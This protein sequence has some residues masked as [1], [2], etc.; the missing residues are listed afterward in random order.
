VTTPAHTEFRRDV[1][2]LHI[3]PFQQEALRLAQPDF[4][5]A[6]PMPFLIYQR[7]QLWDRKLLFAPVAKASTETIVANYDDLYAGGMTFLH[8]IRKLQ[9]DASVPGIVLGRGR[10][11]DMVVPVN[12]VSSAH[13]T[14]LPPAAAGE[15]WRVKDLGSKNGT[16]VG[17]EQLFANTPRPLR[18]GVY[19]RL[20]GTLIGWYLEPVFLWEALRNPAELRRYTEI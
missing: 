7:S 17:E 13:L 12:S 3:E 5:T 15:P 11:Q 18:S 6:Y 2:P 19:L 4:A 16:W 9:T 10:A 14:F 8:P 20:G 1:L